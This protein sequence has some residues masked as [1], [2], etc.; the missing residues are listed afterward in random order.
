MKKWKKYSSHGICKTRYHNASCYLDREN[1][2]V[3]NFFMIDFSYFEI[4]ASM[5]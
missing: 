1:Y 5:F 2:K 3:V 4:S